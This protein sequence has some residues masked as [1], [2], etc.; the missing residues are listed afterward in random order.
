MQFLGGG[1]AKSVKLQCLGKNDSKSFHCTC[2]LHHDSSRKAQ[3][4]LNFKEIEVFTK[5]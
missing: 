1:G 5:F 2:D 4:I 3:N